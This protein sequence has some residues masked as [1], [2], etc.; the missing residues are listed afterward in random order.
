M[1][2]SGVLEFVWEKSSLSDLVRISVDRYIVGA[3]FKNR[4]CSKL[5]KSSI[6]VPFGREWL[7][8]DKTKLTADKRSLRH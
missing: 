2:V 3:M 5:H 8:D 7:G 6:K 4:S 1:N